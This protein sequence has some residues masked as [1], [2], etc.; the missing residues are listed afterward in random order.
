M[1]HLK[2]K[3]NEVALLV[4]SLFRVAR[5]FAGHQS[6]RERIRMEVLKALEQSEIVA[7]AKAG[8]L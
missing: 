3:D 1:G 4:T 5:K 2:M 8:T 7:K 6:L